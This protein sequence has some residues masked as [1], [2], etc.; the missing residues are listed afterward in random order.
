MTVTCNNYTCCGSCFVVRVGFTNGKIEKTNWKEIRTQT[1]MDTRKLGTWWDWGGEEI[2]DNIII[3]LIRRSCNST[4]TSCVSG[5]RT[6]KI[7]TVLI[8]G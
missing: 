6:N 8:D 3:I 2:T 7:Q 4:G 1:A 5:K